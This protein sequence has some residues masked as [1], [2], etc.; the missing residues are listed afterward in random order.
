LESRIRIKVKSRIRIHI[1]GVWIRNTGG[2]DLRNNCSC[3]ETVE[4]MLYSVTKAKYFKTTM[5]LDQHFDDGFKTFF[6]PKF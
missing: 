5:R 6:Q 3:G 4:K 2:L 1:K